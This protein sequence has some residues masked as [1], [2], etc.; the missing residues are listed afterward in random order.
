M[1]TLPKKI[2]IQNHR[3]R[4]S[5]ITSKKFD[6]PYSSH[7]SSSHSLVPHSHSKVSLTTPSNV[8]PVLNVHQFDSK[9]EVKYDIPVY[10]RQDKQKLFTSLQTILC[11]EAKQM[12]ELM[13]LNRNIDPINQYDASDILFHLLI[14]GKGD[15]LYLNLNEQLTDMFRLGQCPQGRTI[16]LLSLVNAFC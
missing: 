16:R 11:P 7:S 8:N 6:N 1:Q 15:D 12:V 10:P 13:K 4:Q 9:L 3:K 2:S 5:S 14:K